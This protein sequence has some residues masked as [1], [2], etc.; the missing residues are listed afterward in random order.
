M[1]TL[2]TDFNAM[3]PEDVCWLLSYGGKRLEES[4]IKHE[5]RKGMR[6]LLDPEENFTVIGVL[7]YV[8]V[9]HLG[10]KSWVLIQIGQ[11]KLEDDLMLQK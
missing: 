3:F 5:L 1:I 8:F 4:D 10:R 2:F 6:V 9:D 11:Q 7:D